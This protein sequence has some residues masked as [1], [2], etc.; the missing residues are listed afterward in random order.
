MKRTLEVPLDEAKR[1]F[2]FLEKAHDLMHQPMYYR[3]TE[4]VD[5]FVGKNYAEVKEL[6][7]D[8]VWNWFP[9]DV[10]REIEGE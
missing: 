3:D 2:R 8:I 9:E 1:L 6:Y 5:K 7:Y 4:V 10:Q